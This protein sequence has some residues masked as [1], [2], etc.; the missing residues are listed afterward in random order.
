MVSK[1]KPKKKTFELSTQMTK[2][3]AGINDKKN[4]LVYVSQMEEL[5]ELMKC[6]EGIS[7]VVFTDK[8]A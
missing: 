2:I 4:T 3:I 6:T 8:L 1:N 7:G 5:K